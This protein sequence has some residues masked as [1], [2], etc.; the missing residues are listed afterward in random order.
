MVCAAESTSACPAAFPNL[1]F[2][3]VTAAKCETDQNVR[4]EVRSW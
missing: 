4:C 3:I 2:E 1:V